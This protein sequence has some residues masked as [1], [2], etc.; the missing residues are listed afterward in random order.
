M[1]IHLQ[2]ANH[3]HQQRENEVHVEVIDEVLTP[4]DS[5]DRNSELNAGD[6]AFSTVVQ[7]DV[8]IDETSLRKES[9]GRRTIITPRQKKILMDFY[10][11]GMMNT[12]TQLRHLHEAASDQTGLDINVIKVSKVQYHIISGNRK[13]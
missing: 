4:E 8:G 2:H 6:D 5:S 10:N 12:S 1:N 11:T 9:T 7:A 13:F 3:D